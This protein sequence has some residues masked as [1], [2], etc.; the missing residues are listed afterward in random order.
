MSLI[1]STQLIGKSGTIAEVET[2]TLA[3]RS[4]VRPWDVSIQGS[5][6]VDVSTVA[7]SSFLIKGHTAGVGDVTSLN[8]LDIGNK[9]QQIAVVRRISLNL[10]V[11]TLLNS[12]GNIKFE[13]FRSPSTTI[14]TA[15]SLLRTTQTSSG[16][17]IA[18]QSAVVGGAVSVVFDTLPIVS[19]YKPI[20][21]TAVGTQV[22]SVASDGY[23]FD[24][25]PGEMPLILTPGE[26][27]V[28]LVT[29]TNSVIG[30]TASTYLE[31]DFSVW[32]DELEMFYD[33]MP[34]EAL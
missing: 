23:F 26:Y 20:T 22:I 16:F 11:N 27:Y 31:G 15:G 4:V 25:R 9:G 10:N 34:E 24:Q 28:V 21:S 33:T 6:G 13:L 14:G 5:Y 32:W 30:N 8:V 7:G 2:N 12:V 29:T 17:S 18:G 3:G 19:M 1:G